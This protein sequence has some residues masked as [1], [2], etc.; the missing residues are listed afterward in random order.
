MI[1]FANETKRTPGPSVAINCPRCGASAAPASSYDQEERFSLLHLLP[2][3][4]L[5]NTFVECQKCLKPLR[6][7]GNSAELARLTAA[8]LEQR[9]VQRPTWPIVVPALAAL[10]LF[11]A[12]ILGLALPGLTL[13]L[14]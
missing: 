12:P 4:V 10:L 9:L 7:R 11:W 13:L 1:L 3:V 5:K 14:I 6:A 8:E 2:I